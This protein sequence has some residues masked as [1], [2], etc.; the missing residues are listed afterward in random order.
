[1]GFSVAECLEGNF[2]TFKDGDKVC[3]LYQG[4]YDRLALPCLVVHSFGDR[5]VIN[6][7][8]SGGHWCEDIKKKLEESNYKILDGQFCKFSY[9]FVDLESFHKFFQDIFLD[10]Y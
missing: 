10:W 2:M 9:E 5:V 6:F 7:W 1:M 3:K 4:D 8:N